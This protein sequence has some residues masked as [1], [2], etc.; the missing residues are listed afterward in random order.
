VEYAE[1]LYRHGEAT[2]RVID[3]PGIYSFSAGALDEKIAREYILLQK[4]DLVVNIVDASNL[5]RNLYLTTQLIE[6]RAPVI[7]ALNM[8]DMAARRGVEIDVAHLERH[9]GCAVVP[10]VASRRD[11]LDALR[12]A[13]AAHGRER[14]VPGTRVAYDS[15]VEEAL[16]TLAGRAAG[17]AAAAGVDARW[18]AVKLLERDPLAAVLSKGALDAVVAAEVRRIAQHTGDAIEIV[19]ADGR[20]GFIHGLARDVVRRSGPFRRRFSDEIDRLVLNRVLGI[21][22]FLGVMALV[23]FVTIRVSAPFINFLD[24]LLQVLAVDGARALLEKARA[25]DALV[26]LLADGLGGGV[27]TVAALVPPVFFIFL[28]LSILEDSGYMARAAFIMDHWMRRLGLP[29]KAFLPLLVGFGCNVPAI[30]AARTLEDER[31][32]L[33]TVLISPFMSCGARFPVYTLFA[34][35]FFPRHGTAAI[36]A[37][38]LAGV[39]LAMATAWALR[40]TVLRGAPSNFVMELPPYHVPTVRGILHHT[41]HRLSGFVVRAGK[42]IVMFVVILSVLTR[43]GTDGRFGDVRPRDSLLAAAGRSMTPAFRPMGVTDDNWPAVVGLFSGIFAKEAVVGTLDALYGSMRAAE[44]AGEPEAYS[45]GAGLRGAWEELARGLRPGGAE[46]DGASGAQAAHDAPAVSADALAALRSGFGDGR[47][48]FAY[49]LFVLTYVPCVA[50][51]AAIYREAGAGWAAFAVAYLSGLAWVVA[52]VFY[53]AATF[54]KHPASSS[55]WL[56][57]CALAAAA[58][59]GLLSAAAR[60]ARGAEA[61]P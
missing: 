60:R 39:A 30:L 17:L 58:F 29:G 5:E 16:A 28:C 14:R 51:V 12:A 21:P 10:I 54:T 47:T 37:L 31:D 23:F 3:L 19:M 35:A 45:L 44:S 36:F 57:L 7:V 6:M 13:I 24:R 59:Y 22:V 33:T 27:Q 55:A 2:V 41:W 25:P 18:M 46:N 49:L 15:E 56:A 32:R 1:G 48:A 53:Q 40:R 4:P 9:L 61:K 8:M 11:G 43:V 38:Y 50:A 26:M 34:V 42:V 20:Y 52:T